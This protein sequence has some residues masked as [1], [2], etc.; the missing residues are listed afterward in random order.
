[1]PWKSWARSVSELDDLLQ[2]ARLEAWKLWNG[3]RPTNDPVAYLV[4]ATRNAVS[5][6]ANKL[7][8]Y[9]GNRFDI[10]DMPEDTHEPPEPLGRWWDRLPP[11][12]RLLASLHADGS[13][14][15]E[16]GQILGISKQAAQQRIARIG[17]KLEGEGTC[18]L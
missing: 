15:Q 14:W 11:H 6:S 16:C 1:M 8:K 7:K 13:S 17:R 9:H 18:I 12:D 4:A 10:D 3:R 2:D 5:E